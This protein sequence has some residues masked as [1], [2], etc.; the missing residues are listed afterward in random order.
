MIKMKDYLTE[1]SDYVL[2]YTKIAGQG[3]KDI[4]GYISNE[5]GDPVFKI[6]KIV[7]EDNTQLWVEGEHDFPYIADATIKAL[8]I[9]EALNVLEMDDEV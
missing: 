8:G 6:R 1:G 7:L 9:M 4:T 2:S 3:I 5:L